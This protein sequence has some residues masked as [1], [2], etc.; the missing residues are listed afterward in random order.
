[1]YMLLHVTANN[2]EIDHEFEREQ[3]RAYGGRKGKG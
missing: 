1:M 3:E 2:E